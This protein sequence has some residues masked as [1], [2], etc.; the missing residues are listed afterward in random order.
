MNQQHRFGTRATRYTSIVIFLA[1]LAGFAMVGGHELGVESAQ[2]RSL[3]AMSHEEL[4]SGERAQ[5]AVSL[6][7]AKLIA[8]RADFVR[9]ALSAANVRDAES[10]TVRAIRWLAPREWSFL[11]VVFGWA[12]GLSLALAIGVKQSTRVAGRSALV[13]G[14]L[15]AVSASGVVESSLTARAMSVVRSATGVL[16]A[17]YQGAGAAADLVPGVVVNVAARYGDFIQVRDPNGAQGWVVA[18]ALEPVL[19]S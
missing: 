1:T 18:N 4:R 10:P 14:L 17:P 3:V 6:E 12:A 11:L 9:S 7:R 5:A 8:P 19:G 16:V 15:F 2:A 13:A